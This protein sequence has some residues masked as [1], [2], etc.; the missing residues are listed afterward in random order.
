[1]DSPLKHHPSQTQTMDSPLKRHPSHTDHGQSIKTA[2]IT[3]QRQSIKTSS[4]DQEHNGHA[5]TSYSIQLPLHTL[6]Y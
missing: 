4:I 3:D 2:S 1:M 5:Y 6:Y